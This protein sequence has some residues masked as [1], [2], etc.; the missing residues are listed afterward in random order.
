MYIIVERINQNIF[1][2]NLREFRMHEV[3]IV[4]DFKKTFFFVLLYSLYYFCKKS[5][6]G[7]CLLIRKTKLCV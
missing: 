2:F 7:H 3:D 5:R 6:Q 4:K 1:T